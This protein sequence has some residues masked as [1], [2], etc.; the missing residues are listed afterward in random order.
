MFVSEFVFI[1][2]DLW[3]FIIVWILSV[4]WVLLFLVIIVCAVYVCILEF[5][6]W[7]IWI[8]VRERD[9]GSVCW[10]KLFVFFDKWWVC[11]EVWF[12]SLLDRLDIVISLDEGDVYILYIIGIW[13]VCED[14]SIMDEGIFFR[15]IIFLFWLVVIGII[16]VLIDCKLLFWDLDEWSILWLWVWFVFWIIGKVMVLD[17]VVVLTVFIWIVWLWGC[18]IRWICI[19]GCVKICLGWKMFKIWN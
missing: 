16:I 11:L 5:I 1:V 4:V 10:D 9:F 19:V 3:L 14:D 2:K 6:F 18:C 15:E 7:C 12:V 17:D 8:V 13:F